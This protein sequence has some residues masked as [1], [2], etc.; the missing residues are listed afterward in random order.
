M[1]VF[2]FI[3]LHAIRKGRPGGLIP[4]FESLN[5][6][7]VKGGELDKGPKVGTVSGDAVLGKVLFC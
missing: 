6:W 2:Q 4:K 3:T 7:G 1:P 5:D